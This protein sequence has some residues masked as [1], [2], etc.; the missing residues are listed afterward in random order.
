MA[1]AAQNSAQLDELR[2]IA[3]RIGAPQSV[4]AVAA[5]CAANILAV[6][7]PCHRIV[8]NDGA[9]S[10]YRWGIDRKRA[11]LEREGKRGMRSAAAIRTAPDRDIEARVEACDWSRVSLDL[12]AQGWAMVHQLLMPGECEA[13]ADLYESAGRFRSKVVM[14]RHGF[15][16]ESTSTPTT[17]CPISSPGVGH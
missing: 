13:I 14:A 3:Q 8:R 9:L 7:I 11:L 2:E 16:R 12:D 15:G 1:G 4:R 5:A 10:G 17:H 6:A